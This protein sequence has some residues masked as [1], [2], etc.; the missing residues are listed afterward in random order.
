MALSKQNN[1]IFTNISPIKILLLSIYQQKYQ[2]RWL[3][4]IKGIFQISTFEIKTFNTHKFW[5]D[6]LISEGLNICDPLVIIRCNVIQSLLQN[7]S[8]VYIP[9]WIQVSISWSPNKH[10]QRSMILHL[11]I[12]TAFPF[13][14]YDTSRISRFQTS[15]QEINGIST[16]E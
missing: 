1:I 9:S 7:N 13:F 6:M 2:W 16:Y 5:A 14:V 8:L 15:K 11:T 12:N 10:P 4:S 3:L